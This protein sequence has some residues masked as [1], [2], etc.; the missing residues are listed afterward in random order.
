MTRTSRVVLL[1]AAALLVALDLWSKGQFDYPPL[2]R[3]PTIVGEVIPGWLGWKPVYNPGGVW[4]LKLPPSVLLAATALAV[5][6]LILWI[7]LPAAPPRV[8]SAGKA[9]VLAGAAGN[10]YDRLRFGQV[11]DFIEVWFGDRDG[12]HWP[13]FNVADASLVVGIGLLLL[14]GFRAK[15]PAKA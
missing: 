2:D 14:A 8:E 1:A 3:P 12:W 6:L 11:R 13:T 5:P 4:S 10:L 7:L 15:R 9:L